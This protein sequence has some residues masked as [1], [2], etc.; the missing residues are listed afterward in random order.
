MSEISELL[1]VINE[2]LKVPLHLDT[3][4][5]NSHQATGMTQFKND[6]LG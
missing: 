3:I 6:T 1:T 5:M 4:C 2:I